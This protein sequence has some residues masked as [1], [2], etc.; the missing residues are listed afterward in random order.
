MISTLWR[1]I[2][3]NKEFIEGMKI[4]SNQWDKLEF[5]NDMTNLT[6]MFEIRRWYVEQSPYNYH[7]AKYT[8]DLAI[9]HKQLNYVSSR[10][11]FRRAI[12]L[13]LLTLFVMG[14]VMEEP[15]RDWKDKFDLKFNTKAYGNLDDA[16]G[17]GSNSIDD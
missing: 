5:K 1:R 17:E 8:N 13:I 14:F 3:R 4:K 2:G 6:R 9:L 10:V 7:N 11:M 15:N 12:G 16:S